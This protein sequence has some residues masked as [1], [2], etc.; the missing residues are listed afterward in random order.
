MIAISPI[1]VADSVRNGDVRELC[2][3]GLCSH[4]HE[5]ECS[6]V[7]GFFEVVFRTQSAAWSEPVSH[8]DDVRDLVLLGKAPAIYPHYHPSIGK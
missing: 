6:L 4:I 5:I 3:H 8:W 7:V 1:L 2:H